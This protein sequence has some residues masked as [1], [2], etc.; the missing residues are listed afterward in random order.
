MAASFKDRILGAARLD[1]ATYEEVEA[2]EGATVQALVVVAVAAASSGVGAIGGG[3]YSFFLGILGPIIGWLVFAVA[4][5]LIGG[6]VL[7]EP[8]TKADAGEILR[9]VGFASSPGLLYFLGLIP[10]L[11]LLISLGIALWVLVA[12]VIAVRQALDYQS[13]A[14]AVGVTVLGW[15]LYLFFARLPLLML[16]F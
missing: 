15:L 11:G 6:M 12:T 9:T 8:G 13:T 16:G 2:D 5:F 14:R 1:V 4:V 3:V 10:F 7:P